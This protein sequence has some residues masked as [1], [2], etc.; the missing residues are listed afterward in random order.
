MT[1][2][3]P[4][5]QSPKPSLTLPFQAASALESLKMESPVKRPELSFAT[6]KENIDARYESDEVAI[7]IKGIPVM[8][9][10]PET[11]VAPSTA[12]G[13]KEDESTEPIL[14]ENAQRFVLFPIKYHEVSFAST[15]RTRLHA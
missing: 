6:D 10:E 15:H 7:P 5:E 11:A 2:P 14:Q 8:D 9:E 13:I 3:P 1:L 4:F 12:P